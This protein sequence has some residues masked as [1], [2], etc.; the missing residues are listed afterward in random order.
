M[1]AG[2]D[3]RPPPRPD[4]PIRRPAHPRLRT[5]GAHPETGPGQRELPAP[6]SGAPG[7]RPGAAR[8]PAPQR[9]A[10]PERP[11][12]PG[13]ALTSSRRRSPRSAATRVVPR[14]AARRAPRAP[15]DAARPPD[16][17]IG[18]RGRLCAPPLARGWGLRGE[19]GG[20]VT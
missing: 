8:P 4:S 7:S 14:P 1:E 2:C 6:S 3:R 19:G 18:S 5:G 12:G 10:D 9:R 15:R 16:R 17:A 13:T 20:G 11:P